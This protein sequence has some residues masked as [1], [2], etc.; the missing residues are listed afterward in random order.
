M[1]RVKLGWGMR[2]AL[3]AALL[4]LGA[5]TAP[6]AAQTTPADQVRLVRLTTAQ[7]GP[8]TPAGAVRFDALI[9]YQLTSAP[10]GFLLLFIFENNSQTSNQ[11]TSQAIWVPSGNGQVSLTIAY[12]PRSDVRTLSLLAGLFRED[13]TLLTWVATN[14]IDLAPWPGRAAFD[15]ALAARLAGRYAE[16]VEALNAAIQQSPDTGNYYYWRADTLLRLQRYDEAIAD[17]SR[18]LA[19]MPGDRASLVG[20]GAAQLWKGAWTDAIADLSAVIDDGRPPDRWTAWAYRGRGVARAALGLSSEAI[21]DYRAYLNL[22]PD[23]PDRA[24]VERWI[25]ELQR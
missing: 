16:A 22:A 17:Y 21:A 11:D 1:G 25:A 8:D 10:R 2:A 7:P 23:A 19:L 14:P 12:Q 15:Q 6:V 5:G 24:D 3:C 4:V 18:A 20:R 9:D 13:Q